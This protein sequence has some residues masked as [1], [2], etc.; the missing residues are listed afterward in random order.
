MMMASPKRVLGENADRNYI[1]GIK[2]A[3][4]YGGKQTNI[5]A[6]IIG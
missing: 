5:Q 3:V 6:T 4:L 2:S 1:T